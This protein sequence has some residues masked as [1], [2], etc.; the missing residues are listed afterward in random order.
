MI[1]KTLFLFGITTPKR[2]EDA[3][4]IFGQFADMLLA[5]ELNADLADQFLLGLEKVDMMLFVFQKLVI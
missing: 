3:L 5:I 4:K 1:P 2:T